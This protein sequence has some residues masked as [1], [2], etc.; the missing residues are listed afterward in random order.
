VLA[1]SDGYRHEALLYR[2]HEGFM[3]EALP[4]VRAALDADEPILVVVE[5]EKID[6]LRR[7]LD[8]QADGV[9]FADMAEVGSNPARIIPA[10]QE[11]VDRHAA[12]GRRLRGIGEPIS[13]RRG[14]AELVECHRHEALLNLAFV[15]SDLWLLCPYDATALEPAV[16]DEA[17]RNHAFVNEHGQ[18][19]ASASF[20]GVA[21]LAGPFDEPLPEPPRAA[22]RL[23]FGDGTLAGLRRFV[24]AH[25]LTAGLSRERTADLVLAASEVATNS[26]V[27]GGGRGDARIWDEHDAVVC[28]V[29]DGG[30]IEDP[31]ADLRRPPDGAVGGRGLWLANQLCELVQVRT[32]PA[33]TAVRLHVRL[34]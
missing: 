20:G 27:H 14:A 34:S 8:G 32:L 6:A 21:A 19:A 25:A 26:L 29:T 9:L 22:P 13:P 4:F 23:T 5:Q 28:E 16:I 7:G 24:A 31:L 12:P 10:W 11:F 17:R 1:T 33:G 30:R 15:G 18:P 3:D 2:G